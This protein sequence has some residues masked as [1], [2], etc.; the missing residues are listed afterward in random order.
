MHWATNDKTACS[1]SLRRN[2][3][4]K[5]AAIARIFGMEIA[6]LRRRTELSKD[7]KN[8]GLE[9]SKLI[10]LTIISSISLSDGFQ[11]SFEHVKYRTCL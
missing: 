7:E 5:T 6:A 1:D 4:Q 8:A 3:M 11:F 10:A 9:V 2:T